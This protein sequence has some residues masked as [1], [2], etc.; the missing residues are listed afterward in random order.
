MTNGL[1]GTR[2]PF[3]VAFVARIPLACGAFDQPKRDYSRLYGRAVF[4]VSLLNACRSC[5]NWAVEKYTVV[6]HEDQ[7][8][9]FWAEVPTLPVCYSQGET[10]NEL[11]ANVREAIAGVREVMKEQGKLPESAIR[12]LDV[13]V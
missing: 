8:G 11:K 10:I 4:P 1:I 7:D 3:W 5:E 6:I 13:A 12:I 2:T 9:E